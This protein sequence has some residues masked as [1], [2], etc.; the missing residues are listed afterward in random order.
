M[1]VKTVKSVS[2]GMVKFAGS[3]RS[4]RVSIIDQMV[5][6]VVQGLTEESPERVIYFL[7]RNETVGLRR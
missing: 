6:H 7:H 1:G 5:V 3:R 4:I 2:E